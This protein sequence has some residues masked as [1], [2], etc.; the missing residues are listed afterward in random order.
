[1]DVARH[2]GGWGRINY[3]NEHLKIFKPE[4]ALPEEYAI[5]KWNDKI[6]KI[7]KYTN[8]IKKLEESGVFFSQPMDIDFAM[9]KSFYLQYEAKRTPP[10]HTTIISVLGNNYF[11]ETQYD[12]S[13]RALFDSYRKIF[14]LGSKPASHIDALSKIS[15]DDLESL[16]PSSLKRLADAVKSKLNS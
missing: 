3:V 10:D 12:D 9:L 5:P 16:M 8:Y 6:H 2:Q 1:M 7:L 4:K 15:Q 13:E 14:K 11:D